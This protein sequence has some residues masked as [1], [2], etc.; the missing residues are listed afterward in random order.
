MPLSAPRSGRP[1]PLEAWASARSASCATG[2]SCRCCAAARA[3]RSR[4][5]ASA[6]RVLGLHSTLGIQTVAI[7]ATWT[8][9]RRLFRWDS[10]LVQTL[11]WTSNYNPLTIVPIYYLCFVT[12]HLLLGHWGRVPGYQA[13]LDVWTSTSAGATW[14][15]RTLAAAAFLGW[16]TLLG[17]L[18]Y[19]V[20]GGLLG[21]AGRY[22]SWSAGPPRAP[23]APAMRS[24]GARLSRA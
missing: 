13:F 20:P 17:C 22:V 7:I 4:P 18:P 1:G 19:C 11:A 2:W 21:T 6:R 5:A 23:G 10:S 14:T 9:A 16:P 8:L 12:G 15:D 3:C 24:A